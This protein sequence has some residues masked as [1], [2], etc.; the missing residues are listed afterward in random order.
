VVVA[1]PERELAVAELE[2]EPA[3]V[4]EESA[5]WK[6]GL[7]LLVVE[8]APVAESVRAPALR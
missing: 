3:V 7:A 5:A 8:L 2:R 1:E 4:V 6:P